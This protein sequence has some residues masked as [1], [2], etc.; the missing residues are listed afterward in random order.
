MTDEPPV[1]VSFP[2]PEYPRALQEARIEG[3]VVLEAVI[4]TLGHPEPASIKVLSSSNRAFEGAA[5]DALRRALYRPG[6]VQGQRVRVL[7]YQ[8]IKFQV[9]K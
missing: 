9:P 4:D 6:R 5:R 8:P 7:V 3:I 2:P 1:R